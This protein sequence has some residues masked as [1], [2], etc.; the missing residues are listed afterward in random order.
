MQVA[1]VTSDAATLEGPEYS[2]VR[3]ELYIL[4]EDLL[5][6]SV[7]VYH[8]PI[9][10]GP[11]LNWVMKLQSPRNNGPQ[12]PRKIHQ[13]TSQ[14]SYVPMPSPSW[15]VLLT[16]LHHLKVETLTFSPK[17]RWMIS[18]NFRHGRYRGRLRLRNEPVPLCASVS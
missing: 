7:L 18:R 16:M 14:V 13:A 11:W 5:V 4:F 3:L 8:I 9:L 1:T 15:S 10:K 2:C 17:T 6:S 12:Q